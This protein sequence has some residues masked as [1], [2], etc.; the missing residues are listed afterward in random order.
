MNNRTVVLEHDQ[1]MICW[2]EM[3]YK[4]GYIPSWDEYSEYFDCISCD[5][6]SF[7]GLEIVFKNKEDK[8]KFILRWV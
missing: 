5:S 3:C 8:V 7:E 2:E 4:L 1:W 6:T